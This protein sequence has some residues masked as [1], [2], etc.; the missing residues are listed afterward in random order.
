MTCTYACRY[1]NYGKRCQSECHC[2]KEHC[3]HFMGCPDNSTS[4][5][6]FKDVSIGGLNNTF[7]I[8]VIIL[9]L[10]SNIAIVNLED[11]V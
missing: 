6:M 5:G 1:P 4:S 11:L 7:H 9:F 10:A 8:A 2:S 3:D